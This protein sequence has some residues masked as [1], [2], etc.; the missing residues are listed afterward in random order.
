[1]FAAQLILL[2]SLAAS[3]YDELPQQE[4]V[5]PRSLAESCGRC[6]NGHGWLDNL[7]VFAG[8]DGSKQPQDLG[9]NA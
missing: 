2:C 1:M 8:L 3:P 9:A 5:P 7:S 6:S 4:Y